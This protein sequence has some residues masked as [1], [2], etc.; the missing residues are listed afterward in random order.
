MSRCRHS[1]RC[2]WSKFEPV[3]LASAAL[4]PRPG[5][6]SRCRQISRHDQEPVNI[7][8]AGGF[9]RLQSTVKTGIGWERVRFAIFD[10][11]G[12]AF[13]RPLTTAD[14]TPFA[15]VLSQT[16]C[17]SLEHCEQ[18]YNQIIATGGEGVM[19]RVGDVLHK[20]KP[21]DDDE[22]VVT[23]YN[24]SAQDHGIASLTVTNSRGTFCVA[25]LGFAVRFNPPMIGETV[26]YYFS[27]FTRTGQ[28]KHPKLKCVR[29]PETMRAA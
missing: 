25:G 17:S 21:R 1:P 19:L 6:A 22:A 12:E 9:E 28:P 27:G 16:Q 10:V 18:F 2:R 13:P 24:A 23:G 4:I 3:A 14:A 15:F 11:P 26:T 8:G 5:A 20:L 7:G 29:A